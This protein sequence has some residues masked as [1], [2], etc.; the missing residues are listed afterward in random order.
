MSGPPDE[1]RARALLAAL[2]EP[3]DRP[4]VSDYLL[5]R[6]VAAW[7]PVQTL[8][9]IEAGALTA[10]A[11]VDA[12]PDVAAA[13][14]AGGRDLSA[15]FSTVSVRVGRTLC[16]EGPLPLPDGVRFV[17]PEDAEWPAG[18]NDLELP[19]LGLW[20]RGCGDLAELSTRSV[21]LVGSRSCTGYGEHV[22]GELGASLAERGWTVTSGG[23]F[24]VDAAAHRGALAA[25]GTTVAV[26]ACGVD[27]AYPRAHETL[28][29]RILSAGA[30][31]SE[32]PPGSA[33]LRHR[34]LAR[35]R[36]IAAM[37]AGTVIVEAAARSGARNTVRHARALGRPVMAVPGPVTSALSV[38][39]HEE[40]RH[41]E[42]AICVARGEEVL[43][44]VGRMGGDLATPV[45]GERTGR[46]ALPAGV[47]RV[48][49]AV[50]VRRT[51]P[52][53]RIAAVAGVDPRAA[54]RALGQLLADG[55]VEQADGGY[56]LTDLGRESA[57]RRSS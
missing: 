21:A 48:L 40:L 1:R 3:A 18:L 20:V 5:P 4:D 25:G 39:C 32:L 26:L 57:E 9:R 56:R 23:A 17:A 50:P 44:V 55:L 41:P 30:V 42:P 43:E 12:V 2:V 14:A 29:N 11:V 31:V 27:I 54:R 38:G 24:G 22:A 49:E 35:N 13:L 16:R 53:P 10:A 6:L 34:F 52:T 33:P 51:A 47:R 46:D 36:L 19:P 28:L 15:L 7:G 45:Q 8:S 37:T